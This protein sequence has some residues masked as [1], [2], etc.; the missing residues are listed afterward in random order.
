MVIV[1]EVA[2]S[3]ISHV[4]KVESEAHV[5][6]EAKL[7]LKSKTADNLSDSVVNLANQN[8]SRLFH[9]FDQ[10]KRD[11]SIVEK[12]GIDHSSIHPAFIKLGIECANDRVSGSNERCLGFL[13]AF[14]SFLTD[15]KAPTNDTKTISKD[16][17]SKLKPN[18]KFDLKKKCLFKKCLFK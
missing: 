3:N 15:Y 11:Y 16:L 1:E 18:I 7:S 4:I 8:K 9:H 14:K 2:H 10:F 17:D 13:N 12:Y 6:V 5:H